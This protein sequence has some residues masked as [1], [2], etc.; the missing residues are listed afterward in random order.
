MKNNRYLIALVAALGLIPIVLDTTIVTVALTSIRTDLHTDVNTVQWIVTGFFLANAAVVA[1]GGYLANRFGR[2]RMFILGLTIFTIGSVLCGLSPSI[3]WLI[4][5]RVMQGMGGGIL[6]PIGPALAFDSFAQEERAKA[7]A[8]VA[9]PVLLA[10]VFGPILGGWLNDAF[11]WHS[12]FF[13]NL[14]VGIIAVAAAFF[15]LPNERPG[16]ANRVGFDFVGLALSTLSIIAVV[17]AFKLVTQ[18]DPSTVSATNPGGNLYGW[19]YWLVWALL[20]AGVVLLGVFAFYALRLSRDPALDLRQLGRRD[21]LLS[22]LFTWATAIISFGLLVLLPLYFEAVRLPHLSALDTGLALVPFGVGTI[23]G[24]VVSAALYRA[25]GPRWVIMLAAALGTLSAWMLA[26]AIHPTATASQL[27]ASVQTRAAV[28]AVASADDLRWGLLLVGLSF[29]MVNVPVQTLAL[30][31]L[32]GEALAKASSLF[33]STKL[34]F[35]SIGV[36]IITTIFVDRTQS[37]AT[38]LAH[39]VQA[40]L[41]GSG[42][43][44]SDPQ[45]QTALQA[46]QAQIPVQAG[47]SA[48]QSIFWMIFFG[49][50]ALIVLALLLPGRKRQEVPAAQPEAEPLPVNS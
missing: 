5:F 25:I 40:L 10:P 3:G 43:N 14:P 49:S 47:T 2:K 26:Q 24:T 35:S 1:V 17:Y 29:A 36:A 37:Q 27:I 32:K 48:I 44:L 39:Q 33:L 28:P 7:S 22:S 11:V 38:T 9:V 19:S 4:A 42:L 18:T 30:E 16:E 8:V 13:V 6:L 12:L 45:V 15:V 50:L 34:I 20:G 21:F 31:A 23:L 46:T 41:P